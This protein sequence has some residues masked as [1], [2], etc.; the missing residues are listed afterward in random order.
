MSGFLWNAFITN[1]LMNEF[2][3]YTDIDVLYYIQNQVF[4]CCK[5]LIDVIGSM[6]SSDSTIFY[7]IGYWVP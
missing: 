2:E 1:Q 6:N 7:N 4:I 5:L 3:W